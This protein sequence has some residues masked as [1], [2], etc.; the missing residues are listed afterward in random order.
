M[1]KI[2]F[3]D[4]DGTLSSGYSSMMFLD[5]V[6]DKGL[7]DEG[8][9]H[10]QM[11]YM[12]DVKAGT[13]S[14][15]DWLPAWATAWGAG[16]E[17]RRYSV[18]MQAA[19]DFFKDFKQNIYP[20]S[21]DVVELFRSSGYK[22]IVLSVG[23][24]EIVSVAAQELGVQDA[25]GTKIGVVDDIYTGDVVT[26]LHTP[27]GKMEWLQGVLADAGIDPDECAACGDSFHDAPMLQS[28][29]HPFALNPSP[30]LENT[31]IE[32]GWP[33]LTYETVVPHLKGWL[34]G[35]K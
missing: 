19:E 11:Q 1:D 27:T 29:G 33:C 32:H 28:V 20:S 26:G 12:A 24:Y 22:P 18:V 34:E 31:A 14:Y 5:Y 15:N 9:Y 4:F 17:G 30:E 6:Y 8:E 10:K 13:M 16:F 7:Y 25:I 35:M 3:L 2:A 23:A 21:Y